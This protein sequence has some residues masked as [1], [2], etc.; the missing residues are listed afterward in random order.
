MYVVNLRKCLNIFPAVYV[1]SDDKKILRRA[2]KEGAIGILRPKELCGDTP[3][4]PVYRHA[5]DSMPDA[6]GFVAV[7]ANSPT[8]SERIIESV[9]KLIDLGH[10]EVITCHEDESIYGSVWGMS[11]ARL[12][13]YKD[14]Y[15]PK[16]DVMIIDPSIDIHD[17]KDYNTALR[18]K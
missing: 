3:N 1:S 9:A 2:E 15:H 8:V 12:Y 10:D 18:A 17:L 7:Q 5:F 4:I 6:F 11:K 13:D 14:F 16:P